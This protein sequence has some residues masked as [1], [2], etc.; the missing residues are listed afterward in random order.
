[1]LGFGALL[2]FPA[3]AGFGVLSHDVIPLLFG[4]RWAASGEIANI[5]TLMAI[6]FCMNFFIG[7]ALAAI[8]RSATIVKGSIVQTAATLAL[9]LLAAPFG[10]PWIA[11]AYVFR[12]YLTMPYHLMLFRRDTGISL[13]AML[14]AI[15]PPFTATVAMTVTLLLISRPLQ[16]QVGHGA[17]Y[18]TIAVPLGCAAFASWLILF[19]PQYVRANLATLPSAWRRGASHGS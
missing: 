4:P 10:L 18:L 9:S 14:R 7:P 15:M 1:M 2:T 12:A 11:A 5:L 3:I 8:G 17:I 13:S 16:Y 6:P 19:T